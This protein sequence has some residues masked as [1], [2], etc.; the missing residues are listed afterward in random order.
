MVGATIL[1][2][3]NRKTT[4][5]SFPSSSDLGQAAV[6]M[7]GR[8]LVPFRLRLLQRLRRSLRLVH[9]H[10]RGTGK[11]LQ[12]YVLLGYFNKPSRRNGL[13]NM[14]NI[15][16]NI[17]LAI[18]LMELCVPCARSQELTQASER[19][20]IDYSEVMRGDPETF[21]HLVV[22]INTQLK[23]QNDVQIFC[24]ISL[25]E[26]KIPKKFMLRNDLDEG[27][28]I[29][30]IGN[31]IDLYLALVAFGAELG[32]DVEKKGLTFFLERTKGR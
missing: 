25:L 15:K 18:V 16:L 21:A 8:G 13:E 32:F 10:F 31:R 12:N 3:M 26:V 24:D 14:K 6:V 30:P 11:L 5:I 20:A 9:E 1:A 2:K 19:V 29:V 23:D 17:L 22:N 7:P 27:V 4:A 28:L